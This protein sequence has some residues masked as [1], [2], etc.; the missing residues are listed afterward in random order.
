MG[1]PPPG[2]NAAHS[3]AIH[4]PAKSVTD[5][6]SWDGD[7]AR[8][9]IEQ[10]RNSCLINRGGDETAKENY[11][12]P[13]RD[14]DGQL[15]RKGLAA[16][17]SRLGQVEGISADKRTTVARHI[18]EL[19]GRV[20]LPVPDGLRVIAGA[21][22]RSITHSTVERRSIQLAVTSDVGTRVIFGYASKFNCD[23]RLMP[24]PMGRGSFKE[25][26]SPGFFDQAQ[27]DGWPGLHGEGVVARFNHS[28][29]HTL[30]NTRSGTLQ[31]SV[32]GVGL[33]YATDVP[34]SRDDVLDLV[35]RGNIVNS[36]FTFALA[37]DLWDFS[38]GVAQRTLISGVLL[39]VAP[40]AGTAAYPD[41]TCALRSLAAAKEVPFDD[42]IDLAARDELRRLWT[43]SDRPTTLAPWEIAHR[44]R[45]RVLHLHARRMAWH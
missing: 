27:A 19:Y 43:R 18:I 4:S 17:A 8:F 7:P 9:T 38:N 36:S 33:Q 6:S 41:T 24:Q 37:Q 35:A 39:D 5:N 3:T 14:P 29:L 1:H 22:T 15:N 13:V 32:D 40:V 21:S 12:L 26:V 42:V 2:S 31:L 10:W 16:A 44:N 11:S 28:D 45:E 23:S 20:G 30:G 25:R 34:P